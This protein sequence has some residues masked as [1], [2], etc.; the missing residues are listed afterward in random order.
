MLKDGYLQAM[1]VV[2]WRLRETYRYY[3]LT[4]AEQCHRGGLIVQFRASRLQAEQELLTAIIRALK[5]QA[6]EVQVIPAA[7]LIVLGIAPSGVNGATATHSL[8]AMLADLKLKAA[9]WK[10]LQCFTAER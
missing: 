8:A 10:A 2:T 6:E 5:L 7:P 4:D 3:R 9:V 1:G